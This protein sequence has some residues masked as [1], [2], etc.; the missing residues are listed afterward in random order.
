MTITVTTINAQITI[1]TT[2]N[3]EKSLFSNPIIPSP[4]PISLQQQFPSIF[5]SASSLSLSPSLPQDQQHSQLHA[6]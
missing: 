2:F 6:S 4:S 1:F 3:N 5:M